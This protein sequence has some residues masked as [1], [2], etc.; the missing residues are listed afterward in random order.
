MLSSGNEDGDP[1]YTDFATFGV[2]EADKIKI[3]IVQVETTSFTNIDLRCACR[4]YYIFNG[5]HAK[6]Q[7]G[8]SAY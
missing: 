3:S 8:G 5:D 6:P 2:Q 7:D 1:L 4:K